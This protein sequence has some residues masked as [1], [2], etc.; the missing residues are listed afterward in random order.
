MLDFFSGICDK[1]TNDILQSII[2]IHSKNIVHRDIKP[3]NILTKNLHYCNATQEDDIALFRKIPLICKLAGLSESR[4]IIIHTRVLTENTRNISLCRGSPAY[5][6]PEISIIDKVMKSSSV[7]LLKAIDVWT[8]D[9]IIFMIINADQ[10]YPYQMNCELLKKESHERHLLTLRNKCLTNNA[11]PIFSMN[12]EVIQ[13]T[14]YPHIREMV[15]NYI[16]K[17]GFQGKISR[18]RIST[19]IGN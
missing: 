8:F 10:D 18:Y 14:H 5:I 15:L 11:Y 12:Y 19:I 6:A 4:S 2:Y 9:L 7:E 3:A 1:I 13:S 16:Y 17:S